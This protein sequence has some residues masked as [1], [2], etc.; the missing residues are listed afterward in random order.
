MLKFQRQLKLLL[1]GV[2]WVGMSA[3]PFKSE[4]ADAE[5]C[6]PELDWQVDGEEY[7]SGYFGNI[8]LDSEGNVV[9]L[10]C[11]ISG[12]VHGWLSE[13]KKVD[14][15]GKELWKILKPEHTIF[16]MAIDKNDNIVLSGA[17][18]G[19]TNP[20][21]EKIDSFGASIW[22]LSI[23]G[24]FLPF[25]AVAV[26]RYGGVHAV[27]TSNEGWRV[28][29][30]D[31]T[32]LYLSRDTV[33]FGGMPMAGTV[34]SNGDRVFVGH[35]YFWPPPSGTAYISAAMARFGADGELKCRWEYD[36]G[37]GVAGFT[38]IAE[39]PDGNSFYVCGNKGDGTTVVAKF[40]QYTVPGTCTPY[41]MS[42]YPGSAN[43]VA[44]GSDHDIWL[45][46]G[47]G[48]N[49]GIWRY[50]YIAGEYCYSA[51]EE[52]LSGT[53]RDWDRSGGLA[54]GVGSNGSMVTSGA[55]EEGYMQSTILKFDQIGRN[56]TGP[57]PV[58]KGNPTGPGADHE[59]GM[60]P[61]EVSV[62]G[63]SRGLVDPMR[64][65]G[66]R[67]SVYPTSAGTVTLTVIDRK[68]GVVKQVSA[69]ASGSG[70]VTLTWDGKNAS[71]APVA[72]GIYAVRV[73]GPGIRQ[74]SKVAVVY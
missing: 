21:L 67:V 59:H 44:V 41:Y 29:N 74:V 71:G 56:G 37:T 19:L 14:S 53:G 64:G 47:S 48:G 45:T 11:G 43:G 27:G 26:D 16:S 54:I 51:S 63:G 57:G 50:P 12:S 38:G 8:A 33:D 18:G 66:A 36:P 42:S 22:S 5:A 6:I 3:I 73:E 55:F 9:S 58:A 28:F 10:Y 13:I 15:S 20:Y 1:I 72:P 7:S 46:G 30:F 65:E 31:P 49:W 4:A 39:D 35:H 69:A 24:E 23:T 68:G 62:A 2:L 32:G 61:G 70:A 40:E 60:K 34:L 25:Y 52:W 17:A